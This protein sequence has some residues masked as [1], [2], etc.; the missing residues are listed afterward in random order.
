MC[1]RDIQGSAIFE[2][3][4]HNPHSIGKIPGVLGFDTGL[5]VVVDV[6]ADLLH[7]QTSLGPIEY[8]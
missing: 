6:A 7:L 8:M 5:V 3:T 1:G 4:A 2:E